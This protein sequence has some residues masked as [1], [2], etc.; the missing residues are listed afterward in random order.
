MV[1]VVEYLQGVHGFKSQADCQW[2]LRPPSDVNGFVSGK[3]W[4]I[5]RLGATSGV[6][7]VEKQRLN[8]VLFEEAQNKYTQVAGELAADTL[9]VA[10][11]DQNRGQGVTKPNM[12][13]LLWPSW[14]RRTRLSRCIHNS[15]TKPQTFTSKTSRNK[16]VV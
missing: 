14:R 6:R 3:I 7:Q 15:W 16:C 11:E 5:A 10:H 13:M 4:A 12:L 2:A 8:A 1:K 9:R